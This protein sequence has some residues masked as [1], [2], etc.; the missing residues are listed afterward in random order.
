MEVVLGLRGKGL[1]AGGLRGGLCVYYKSNY[2]VYYAVYYKMVLV[3][4]VYIHLLYGY[5]FH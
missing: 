1:V 5:L 3:F 2:T 4:A